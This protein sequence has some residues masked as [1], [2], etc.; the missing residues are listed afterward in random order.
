MIA[1]NNFAPFAP[2]REVYWMDTTSSCVFG[3]F[4]AIHL[5]KQS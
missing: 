3:W 5:T 2:L 4:V 1:N